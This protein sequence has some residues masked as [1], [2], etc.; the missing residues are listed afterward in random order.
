[1]IQDGKTIAA[2]IQ[3]RLRIFLCVIVCAVVGLVLFEMAHP[4]KARNPMALPARTVH[5]SAAK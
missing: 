2:L 1:M 5:P 3:R 4:T